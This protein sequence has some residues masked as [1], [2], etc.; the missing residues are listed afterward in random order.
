[1]AVTPISTPSEFNSDG[2]FSLEKYLSPE[3]PPILSA[4]SPFSSSS[5]SDA[6]SSGHTNWISVSSS[7]FPGAGLD[8]DPPDLIILTSDLV[9]FYVHSTRLRTASDNDFNMLLAEPSLKK[10]DNMALINVPESSTVINIVLHA[11]YNISCAQY[12]PSLSDLSAAVAA[13]VT[14]GLSK[15][16]YLTTS[17]PLYTILLTRAPLAPLEVYTL[18]G[19][20][21][22]YEL[23]VSTS[24]FLLS[25][26]LYSISDEVATK[27]GAVYLKRLFLLHMGLTEALK[28][29]LIDPPKTHFQT[30]NCDM[31][32]QSKLGRAWALAC[33]YLS[34]QAKPAMSTGIIE[35]ALLP[36]CE[37]LTCDLCK[38]SLKARVRE[39]VEKWALMKKTI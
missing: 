28:N 3:S 37:H 12:A 31:A 27:M 13:L 5:D 23:A 36:L 16:T 25:T 18:A 24:P 14:Y 34:W 6:E 35:A 11:I 22:L 29:V 32:E 19:E 38:T 17:S 9:F 30:E 2:Y 39:L 7:F 20:Y 4:L 10:V 21:D 15:Q 1:M 26:P 8:I 33:A